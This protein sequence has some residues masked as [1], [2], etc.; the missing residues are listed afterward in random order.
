[1]GPA[2]ISNSEKSELAPFIAWDVISC[3][4]AFSKSDVKTGS[5]MTLFPELSKTGNVSALSISSLPQI[6]ICVGLFPTKL[7][8][9]L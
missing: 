3:H 5:E 4:P 2:G 7:Q 8:V 6:S 1:M 9:G